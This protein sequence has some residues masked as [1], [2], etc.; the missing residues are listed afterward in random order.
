MPRQASPS[1]ACSTAFFH[2]FLEAALE[3]FREIEIDLKE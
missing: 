1:T 3:Q 2:K